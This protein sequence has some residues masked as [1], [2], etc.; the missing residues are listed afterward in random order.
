M[1]GSAEKLDLLQLD[2]RHY[3]PT[4]LRIAWKESNR[5][6]PVEEAISH[7][8]A[9]M[10]G[11]LHAFVALT[12]LTTITE[13]TSHGYLLAM[14]W[15]LF[16]VTGAITSYYFALVIK[17]LGRRTTYPKFLKLFRE[18]HASWKDSPED[19]GKWGARELRE[20][21]SETLVQLAREILQAESTKAFHHAENTRTKFRH[22]H[23]AFHGLGLVEED[24]TRHFNQAEA[25]RRDVNG[26]LTLTHEEH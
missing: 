10:E 22:C 20:K 11:P 12:C 2:E 14:A 19:V 3:I 25:D 7:R 16:S 18:V 17:Q 8:R 21:S 23:A 6:D 26:N 5:Y 9:R 4:F 24:W 1:L 15:L 13:D